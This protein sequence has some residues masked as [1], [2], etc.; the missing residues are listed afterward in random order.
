[1]MKTIFTILLCFMT[2]TA[3]TMTAKQ[4]IQKRSPIRER[5]QKRILEEIGSDTVI[6]SIVKDKIATDTDIQRRKQVIVEEEILSDVVEIPVVE[7]DTLKLAILKIL[8]VPIDA[9]T[10]QMITPDV[11]EALLV[12]L[13]STEIEELAILVYDVSSQ[14]RNLREEINISVGNVKFK[15]YLENKNWAMCSNLLLKSG[16]DKKVIDVLIASIG[17]VPAPVDMPFFEGKM[18]Y[19]QVYKGEAD[20]NAFVVG[21]YQEKVH[22]GDVVIFDVSSRS[23]IIKGIKFVEKNKNKIGAVI[24]GWDSRGMNNYSNLDISTYP[25]VMKMYYDFYSIC[26]GIKPDLPVGVVVSMS[27]TWRE[28]LDACEFKFDFVALWNV[29]KLTAN[30][31]KI[32]NTYFRDEQVLICGMNATDIDLTQRYDSDEYRNYIKEIKELG[33]CGS[34]WVKTKGGE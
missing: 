8:N 11:I 1:M 4:G 25:E 6:K 31:E 21:T 15:K 23:N 5:I 26:K 12:N 16:V 24:I 27:I 33:F 34:I 32:K 29:T 14:A 17:K 7:I 3:F 13:E 20:E 9:I 30:F 28:W 2:V 10:I 19:G 18:A 22:Q